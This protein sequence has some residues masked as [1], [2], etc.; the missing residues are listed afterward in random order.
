MPGP[1]DYTSQFTVK[2]FDL[3]MAFSQGQQMAEAERLKQQQLQAAQDTAA[4]KQQALQSFMQNPNPT[5][6]DVLN[7]SMYLDK[8]Q[9]NNLRTGFEGMTKEKQQANLNLA[10]QVMSS[11]ESG[12]PELAQKLLQEKGKN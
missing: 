10:G 1:I 4:Q 11:F 7:L 5:A 12:K 9:A 8:D 6:R 3:G 2:P